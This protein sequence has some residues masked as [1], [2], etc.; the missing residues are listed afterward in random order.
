MPKEPNMSNTKSN[1]AKPL[2]GVIVPIVTPVDSAGKFND[3]AIGRIIDHIIEKGAHGIFVLGSTGEFA[4][5]TKNQHIEVIKSARTYI[6][7]ESIF[8]V[9]ISCCSLADGIE[10]AGT[11]ADLGADYVVST[12]PYYQLYR[13]EDIQAYF[14]KLADASPVPVILYNLPGQTGVTLEAATVL[15][16]SKHPNIV[17]LKESSS[18]LTNLITLCSAL[19]EREDF[20]LLGGRGNCAAMVLLCGISGLVPAWAKIIPGKFR[21]LYD[22]ALDGDFQQVMAIQ[23]YIN[24]LYVLFKMGRTYDPKGGPTS[25]KVAL[26]LM[27]LCGEHRVQLAADITDVFRSR[28]AELLRSCRVPLADP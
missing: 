11:A 27:G 18:D 10:A 15:A 5:M 28:V 4:S 25:L 8:T 1:A 6:P 21:K 14:S 20:A 24:R 9:G 2:A 23:Q 3:P 12:A 19:A 13:Q 22:A 16:L 26:N 7:Q 17:G